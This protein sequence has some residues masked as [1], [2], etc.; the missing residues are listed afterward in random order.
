MVG[1][2]KKGIDLALKALSDISHSFVLTIVGKGPEKNRL[3]YLSKEL[4][5]KGYKKKIKFAGHHFN[6]KKFY[7]K[8]NLLNT[9]HFEGFSNAIIDAMNH[10]I[11]V[12][13]SNCAGAIKKFLEKVNMV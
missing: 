10:N 4:F 12:I 9:S 8:S 1:Y 13:A 5:G 11:P 6:L 7:L 2:I 3:I